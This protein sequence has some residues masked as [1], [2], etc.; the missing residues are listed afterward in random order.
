MLI[1]KPNPV[2]TKFFIS[3]RKLNI[4]FIFITES[5]S[6]T[7]KSIKL[8]STHYFIMKTLNK[9]ELQSLLIIQS[10]IRHCL[11][12]PYSFVV[13]HATLASDNPL[14]FKKNLS[15]KI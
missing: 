2:V 5:Y 6:A 11:E 13:I 3:G 9:P 4:S 10:F 15:E 1:K 14:R 7:P 12:K 8:N